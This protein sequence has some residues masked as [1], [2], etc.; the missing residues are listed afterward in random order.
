MKTKCGLVRT[1]IILHKKPSAQG[2]FDVFPALNRFLTPAG[3]VRSDGDPTRGWDRVS[4]FAP[5]PP[6]FFSVFSTSWCSYPAVGPQRKVQGFCCSPSSVL[7]P[8]VFHDALGVG[9]VPRPISEAPESAWF[10]PPEISC[11][12]KPVSGG[13]K[14][15]GIA[16][17]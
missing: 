12:A 2:R 5:E 10:A 14:S 17:K 11:V 16:P 7:H 13:A 15:I 1:T 9:A 6:L 8:P 3:N 4:S